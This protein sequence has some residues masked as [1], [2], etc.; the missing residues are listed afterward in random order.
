[1]LG[2]GEERDVLMK[3]HPAFRPAQR[4]ATLIETVI[5]L[6]VLGILIV[7]GAPS[8]SDWLQNAQIR[9]GAESLM[10]GLQTARSEAVRRNTNVQFTLTNPAAAGGTGWSVTLVSTGEV[11]QS[12]PDG[13]GARNAIVTPTPGDA[14]AITFT[15]LGRPPSPPANL[16]ADGSTL[17]TQLDIDST[18]L[19]AADSR[20]MRILL[21]TGGQ[22]RMCDPNV[23]DTTDPRAC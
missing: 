20:E 13:E 14:Y 2:H 12:A 6:V 19:A 10:S 7:M 1:M 11:I 5:A 17:L 18:V 22:I 8:L 4:G 3:S 9:T 15:G 23:S 21:S 16:N